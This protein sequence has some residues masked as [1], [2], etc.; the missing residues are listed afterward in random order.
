MMDYYLSSCKAA[1]HTNMIDLWQ[2]VFTKPGE[3][4]EYKTY[5]LS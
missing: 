1:F 4:R 3:L 2:Y 5:R